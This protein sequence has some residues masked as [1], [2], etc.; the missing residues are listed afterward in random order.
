MSTGDFIIEEDRYDTLCN[1]NE[2]NVTSSCECVARSKNLKDQ[3]WNSN[4]PC[5]WRF[6][7]SSWS[8]LWGYSLPLPQVQHR[9]ASLHTSLSRWTRHTEAASR[10]TAAD[11]RVSRGQS[12]YLLIGHRPGGSSLQAVTPHSILEQRMTHVWLPIND[13]S[14][15]LHSAIVVKAASCSCE[16]GSSVPAECWWAL[17]QRKSIQHKAGE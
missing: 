9:E 10:A 1:E 7:P 16:T 13:D 14:N 17:T 11:I 2:L 3:N 6:R 4:L 5:L 8:S 15:C 12:D